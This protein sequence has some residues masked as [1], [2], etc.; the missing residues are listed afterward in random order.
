MN[1]DVVQAMIKCYN[2]NGLAALDK[3]YQGIAPGDIDTDQF[4][5]DAQ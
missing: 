1:N 3:N 2:K 5:L 4:V